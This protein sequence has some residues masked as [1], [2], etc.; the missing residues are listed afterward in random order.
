MVTNQNIANNTTLYIHTVRPLRFNKCHKKHYM[1]ISGIPRVAILIAFIYF[2]VV[3][4]FPTA[5][6]N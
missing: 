1:L 2:R 4:V 6:N 3:S 5:L